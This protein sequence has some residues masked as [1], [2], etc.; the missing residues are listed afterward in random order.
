[1]L[2]RSGK[3]ILEKY[4]I[5]YEYGTLTESIKNR[6]G[7]D[8]CPMEKTVMNTEDLSEAFRLLKAKVEGLRQ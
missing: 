6:V 4:N 3:A 5:P 8:V 2:F 7:T 1:M